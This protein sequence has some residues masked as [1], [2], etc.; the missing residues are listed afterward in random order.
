[1]A[2]VLLIEHDM[3]IAMSVSD[4]M[5]CLEA[6]RIISEGTPD[7]VRNDP[8]V[9]ESYLGAGARSGRVEEVV[10]VT[11]HPDAPEQGERQVVPEG[12]PVAD[13]PDLHLH[14]SPFRSSPWHPRSSPCAHRSFRI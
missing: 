10:R 6:G 5:Y 1:M 13:G 12:G 14:S 11:D 4:R 9:I 3:S 7:H 2:S 8:L